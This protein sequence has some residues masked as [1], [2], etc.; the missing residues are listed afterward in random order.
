[1]EVNAEEEHPL[2]LPGLLS[3]LVVCEEPPFPITP[4]PEAA[5]AAKDITCSCLILLA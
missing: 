4:V 2:P 5:A 1:V 3:E